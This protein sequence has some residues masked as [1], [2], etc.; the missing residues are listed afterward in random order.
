MA[1]EFLLMSQGFNYFVCSGTSK[2][3][4]CVWGVLAV[5]KYIYLPSTYLYFMQYMEDR[6]LL[7]TSSTSFVDLPFQEH[8]MTEK[9]HMDQNPCISSIC[10]K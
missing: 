4:K 1:L 7:L 10:P 8:W 3:S 9:Y 2:S 6:Y 5:I